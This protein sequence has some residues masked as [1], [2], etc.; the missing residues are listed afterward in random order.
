MK[1]FDWT[2]FILTK[3]HSSRFFGL[4]I[5]PHFLVVRDVHILEHLVPPHWHQNT[6]WCLHILEHLVPP[7]WHQNTSWC[8]L[9]DINGTTG[10]QKLHNAQQ[11]TTILS[12][13][14]VSVVSSHIIILIGRIDCKIVYFC[15]RTPMTL[16][17]CIRT[18]E[19]WRARSTSSQESCFFPFVKGG[20][21]ISA[22]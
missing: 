10:S 14:L 18:S 1:L 19:S 15:L 11:I 3:N 12:I 22:Q 5:T 17:T 8:Q 13:I 6:S 16:S 21:L 2:L 4:A 20:T 7:H 9:I